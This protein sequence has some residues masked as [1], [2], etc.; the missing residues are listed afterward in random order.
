MRRDYQVWSDET[1]LDLSY[2]NLKYAA[3]ETER[4]FSSIPNRADCCGTATACFGIQPR[5][6]ASNLTGF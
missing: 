6:L 2:Q 5:L 1:G 3:E 4:A